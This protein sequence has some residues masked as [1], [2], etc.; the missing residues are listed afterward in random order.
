MYKYHHSACCCYESI[1]TIL[2]IT[3]HIETAMNTVNDIL[4]WV[5][6]ERLYSLLICYLITP[7]TFIR[8]RKCLRMYL[9]PLWLW[10]DNGTQPCQINTLHKYIWFRLFINTTHRKQTRAQL[11]KHGI[12]TRPELINYSFIFQYSTLI[13]FKQT[14]LNH[15]YMYIYIY[16]IWPD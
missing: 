9:I 5:P 8:C 12:F 7:K 14:Y 4:K 11:M 10:G 13:L 16:V 3:W 1:S 6:R 15:I 2:T